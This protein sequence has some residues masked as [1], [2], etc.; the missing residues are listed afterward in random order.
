MSIIDSVKKPLIT[1][2]FPNNDIIYEITDK[3]AR[4]RI[5]ELEKAKVQFIVVIND[6]EDEHFISTEDLLILKDNWAN[7]LLYNQNF[8]HI[9]ARSD[10]N[11]TYSSN[12]LTSGAISTI[13]VNIISGR[14]VIHSSNPAQE[15]LNEHILNTSVHLQSGERNTWNNKVSAEVDLSAEELKLI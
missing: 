14:Y 7:G 13:T 8:Y 2:K 12:D 11:W 1:I 9:C 15:A 6:E 3:E 10:N 5:E 4:D